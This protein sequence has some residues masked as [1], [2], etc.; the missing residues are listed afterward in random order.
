[1][2]DFVCNKYK[3]LLL[4]S[5]VSFL[6]LGMCL[7]WYIFLHFGGRLYEL[8][9]ES[10]KVAL[11]PG[12]TSSGAVGTRLE[13]VTVSGT[14][15]L[16]TASLPESQFT[17]RDRVSFYRN[18]FGTRQRNFCDFS[19]SSVKCKLSFVKL[20]LCFLANM[21]LASLGYRS[22]FQNGPR[23][24]QTKCYINKYFQV[25]VSN[26]VKSKVVWHCKM[27]WMLGESVGSDYTQVSSSRDV[28]T[29]RNPAQTQTTR[30]SHICLS[31]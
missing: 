3:I 8:M 28:A 30:A 9:F 26:M 23:L 6:F 31:F 16:P 12:L 19:T 17:E 29:G 21:T 4:T 15:H 18:T 22:A 24:E 7:F 13:N 25:L 1:M 2:S 27:Y 14:P 11:V 20:S 5:I 10:M